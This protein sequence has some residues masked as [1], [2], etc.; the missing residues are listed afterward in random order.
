LKLVDDV[1]VVGIAAMEQQRQGYS[2]MAR[3]RAPGALINT[4]PIEERAWS[5]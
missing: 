3:S 5:R 4:K 1:I 2:G